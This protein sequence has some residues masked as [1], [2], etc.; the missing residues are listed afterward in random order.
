MNKEEVVES[1]VQGSFEFDPNASPI[2]KKGTYSVVLLGQGGLGHSGGTLTDSIIQ[3]FVD[4]INKKA[5]MISVPRD[6]WISIPTDF[7]NETSHKIN[8]AYAVALNNTAYAN[9]KPEYRGESGAGELTKYA[10]EKVTG[11]KADYYAVIDFSSFESLVETLGGLEVVSPVSWDDY[12][13]PIRGKELELCG[14]SP[15]AIAGFHEKYT[16]F[17]L[18]RQFECR[19]EEIHFDKGVNSMD[20]TTALKFVRSRHSDTYGGDFARSEKQFAL[21]TAIGKKL[22]SA[23]SLKSGSRVLNDIFNLVRT[24]LNIKQITDMLKIIGDTGEYEVKKVYLNDSNVLNASKSSAGAFILVPKAGVHD[25]SVIQNFVT[26]SI[27]SKD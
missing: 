1:A 13:Y 18:E 23:N 17:Q 4:T 3:I 5:A 15:E 8:E 16:G 25:F 11:I 27:S 2:S 21:L 6:L 19:Y 22:V 20:G 9:K 10:V 12:F 24:D 14:H 7:E 26:S